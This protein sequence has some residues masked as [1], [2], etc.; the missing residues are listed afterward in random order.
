M[1]NKI[2]S[3]VNSLSMVVWTVT[4]YKIS[5]KKR[6]GQGKKIKYELENQHGTDLE[7]TILETKVFAKSAQDKD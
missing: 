6:V 5:F 2:Y 4:D 3:L 1:V 7:I